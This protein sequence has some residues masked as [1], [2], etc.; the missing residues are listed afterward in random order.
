[1]G[2]V[3]RC[4]MVYIRR[5]LPFQAISHL[6]LRPAIIP[7]KPIVGKHIDKNTLVKPSLE[8]LS[9]VELRAFFHYLRPHGSI[10]L[11]HIGRKQSVSFWKFIKQ[12]VRAHV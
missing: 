4:R 3:Y 11:R 6:P 12:I 8:G 7:A 9:R 2:N 10:A 5:P 1:M